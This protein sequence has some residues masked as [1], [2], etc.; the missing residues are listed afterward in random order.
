MGV[1]GLLWQGDRWL[2]QGGAA[3]GEAGP[4]PWHPNSGQRQAEVACFEEP[5]QQAPLGPPG[6]PEPSEA[7]V[8]VAGAICEQVPGSP[9]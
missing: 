6:P 3:S 8:S 1:V 9:G 2:S 4:Q 7:G 5:A